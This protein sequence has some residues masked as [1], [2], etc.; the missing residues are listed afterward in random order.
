M[1]VRLR[2]RAWA[3][4]LRARHIE[5]LQD[6]P[7]DTKL[8]SNLQQLDRAGVSVAQVA[9][10]RGQRDWRPDAV[11]KA[12]EVDHS[13]GCIIDTYGLAWS[14]VYV[15]QPEIEGRLFEAR[16][17]GRREGDPR[18]MGRSG[19]SDLDGGGDLVG[20]VMNGCGGEQARRA[21]GGPSTAE[22][23]ADAGPAA[24]QGVALTSG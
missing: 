2:M 7:V 15:C 24:P 14:C 13:A 20:Q 19:D 22:P 23:A 16:Y 1:R 17:R 6:W 3:A 8:S 11:P 12:H 4:S 18:G 5:S 21:A 10:E 9:V